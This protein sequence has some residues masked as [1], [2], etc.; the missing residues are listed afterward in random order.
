MEE[1]VVA[2][3][4]FIYDGFQQR[5]PPLHTALL[6]ADF[7]RAYDRVWRKA[8]LVKMAVTRITYYG[9]GGDVKPCSINQ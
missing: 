5:R 6:L 9:V 3:T 7:S 4:Q 8:L 2:V 1:Q